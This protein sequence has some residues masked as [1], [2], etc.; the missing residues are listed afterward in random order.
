MEKELNLLTQELLLTGYSEKNYPDYVRIPPSHF[1]DELLDNM[2]GG[3]E[4]RRDYLSKQYYQ[5][6][7]GL[8]VTEKNCISRMWYMNI[9]WCFEND[10]V[11]IH[12][13]YH[14]KNCHL[15]NPILTGMEHAFCFCSCHMA[16]K[17]EYEN[18]VEKLLE[19]QEQEKKE[20]YEQFRKEY[21]GEICW[22]HMHY[23]PDGKKWS[24]RYDPIKCVKCYYAYCP[25]LYRPLAK[26]KGNVF[27]DVRVSTIRRDGSFFDG[28]PLVHVIKGKKL[29]EKRVSMDICRAAAASD[30]TREAIFRREWWNGYSMQKLYDPDLEVEIINIRAERRECR[31]LEQDLEDIRN[32]ILVVH[33]SDRI[34]NQKEQKRERKRKRQE[35]LE[36]RIEKNGYESLD[37]A[38][39]RQ[40]E[41]QIGKE[42]IKEL[43]E[44]W[45][46]SQEEQQLSLDAWMEL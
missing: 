34:E 44:K 7:C 5:T 23:E 30:S 9:Y 46:R 32:G 21:Q 37:K 3:F 26:E 15:N 14:K 6:G 39:R 24:F 35:L 29:L 38:K 28:E 43:D 1:E 4:F 25:V 22:E 17:Y 20:L 12:C 27:Y 42:R 11:L 19:E 31:D 45:K 2:Y 10:N 13:P 8:Y 18:S 16:V 33:D 40:A 36:R 41:K